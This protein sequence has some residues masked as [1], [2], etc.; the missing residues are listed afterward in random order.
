MLVLLKVEVV[1]K[2]GGMSDLLE[3]YYDNA[4]SCAK[5]QDV[6]VALQVT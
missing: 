6:D 1:S 5:R 4:P 3:M 2:M